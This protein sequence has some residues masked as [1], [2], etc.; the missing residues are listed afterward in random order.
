MGS[1]GLCNLFD[2]VLPARKFV[3]ATIVT[4]VRTDFGQGH[5]SIIGQ[6]SHSTSLELAPFEIRQLVSMGEHIV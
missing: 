2:S 4:V 5:P 6:S 3:F 1:G